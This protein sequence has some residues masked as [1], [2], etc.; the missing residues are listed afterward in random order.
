MRDPRQ[1]RSRDLA[2][3]MYSFTPSVSL[4]DHPRGNIAT[5]VRIYHSFHS[6]FLFSSFARR[7]LRIHPTRVYPAHSIYDENHFPIVSRFLLYP[8]FE[9]PRIKFLT[10]TCIFRMCYISISLYLRLERCVLRHPMNN[11]KSKRTSI[12][13]TEGESNFLA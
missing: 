6:L 2:C 1:C 13:E 12:N 5:S 3:N 7:N 8:R 4:L 11:L 9:I 10:R